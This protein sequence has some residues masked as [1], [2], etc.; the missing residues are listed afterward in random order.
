[1][2]PVTVL[3]NETGL[4]GWPLPQ[5]PLPPGFSPT[6]LTVLAGGG[7][8][9]EL[10]GCG[11]GAGAEVSG[12]GTGAGPWDIGA[13]PWDAEG[14]AGSAGAEVAGPLGR[15]LVEL[16]VAAL[17]EMTWVGAVTLAVISTPPHPLVVVEEDAAVGFTTAEL[18]VVDVLE[19]AAAEVG[20]GLGPD[21]VPSIRG[22]PG[23]V[24]EVS[25]G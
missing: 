19:L 22:G 7:G 2:R 11:G 9:A 17:G 20:A 24:Y 13:G 5:P 3:V 8:G 15:P 10:S 21:E 18:A 1:M 12:C 14:S 23:M 25:L 4:V 6:G 16:V